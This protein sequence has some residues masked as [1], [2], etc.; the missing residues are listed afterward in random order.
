MIVRIPL[1]NYTLF[2]LAG[3][4]AGIARRAI[5][6]ARW[7]MARERGAGGDGPP[8]ARAASSYPGPLSPDPRPLLLVGQGAFATEYTGE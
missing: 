7:L 4:S 3:R 1:V 5:E 2:I 6:A 8:P